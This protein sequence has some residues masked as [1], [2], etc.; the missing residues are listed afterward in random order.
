MKGSLCLMKIKARTP[1]N[2]IASRTNLFTDLTHLWQ[3]SASSTTSPPHEPREPEEPLHSIQ[4]LI[5]SMMRN[6][7]SANSSLEV[8]N[9]LVK[10]TVP[11]SYP[12]Y[13]ITV[14]NCRSR[15]R[16]WLHF[17]S[18]LGRSDNTHQSLAFAGIA[19]LLSTLSSLNN[20][21]LWISSGVN[22]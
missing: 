6:L 5:F 1:P 3:N 20:W 2:L 18:K 10:M 15:F 4:Q 12:N 11:L 17:E 21:A 9:S 14:E 7:A 22:T 8:A 19:T 16:S 13:L